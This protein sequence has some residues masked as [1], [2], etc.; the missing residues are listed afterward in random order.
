MLVALTQPL[1]AV[2]VVFAPVAT[3]AA[4]RLPAVLAAASV[5]VIEPDA[6]WER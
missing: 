6:A 2:T 3:I 1:G 4:R 5:G